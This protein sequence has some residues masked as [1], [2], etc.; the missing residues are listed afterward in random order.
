VIV[1]ERLTPSHGVPPLAPPTRDGVTTAVLRV[2]CQMGM[3]R[4]KLV[5]E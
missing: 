4:G 1:R 5:V 3:L 2:A